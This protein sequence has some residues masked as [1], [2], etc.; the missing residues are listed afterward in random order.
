MTLKGIKILCLLENLNTHYSRSFLTSRILYRRNILLRG[1]RDKKKRR[2]LTKTKENDDNK[3]LNSTE[4]PSRFLY[5][6]SPLVVFILFLSSFS[7]FNDFCF[8]I[9]VN[10][11]T[12]FIHRR[13]KIYRFS[14]FLSPMFFGL[15]R[16]YIEIRA[17]AF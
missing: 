4:Y 8:Y 17:N 2:K 10:R 9:C 11:C 12:Y 15:L 6:I 7:L 16:G 5:H 1:K 13:A 14:F 3:S